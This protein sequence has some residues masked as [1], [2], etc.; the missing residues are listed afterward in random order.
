MAVN[1]LSAVMDHLHREVRL[2]AAPVRE[3]PRELLDIAAVGDLTAADVHRL[4]S[5][6]SW[7]EGSYGEAFA[8]MVEAVRHA[9]PGKERD[10]AIVAMAH[11]DA[12]LRSPAHT[13]AEH[14]YAGRHTAAATA[15]RQDQDQDRVEGALLLALL[16]DDTEALIAGAHALLAEHGP[17]W[18]DHAVTGAEPLMAAAARHAPELFLALVEGVATLPKWAAETAACHLLS[19]ARQHLDNGAKDRAA[20]LAARARELLDNSEGQVGDER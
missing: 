3:A 18:P 14:L 16:E 15:L 1:A 4:L 12:W 11:M 2:G 20:S 9:E 13:I 10:D 19:R 6:R 17:S 8:R 5:D 7:R